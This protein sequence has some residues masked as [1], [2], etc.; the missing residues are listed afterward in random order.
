MNA[1]RQPVSSPAES[2]I[3]VDEDDQEIGFCSKAECHAGE[4]L[5]HRA[6]SV[7]IF[8]SEG[9]LLLQQRSGQKPLW[10]LIWANSCCSHP[11]ELELTEDAARRRV[12]EE[13][14][15]NCELDFLYKFRYQANYR[16][17]GAEHELCH[18]FA[19]YSDEAPVAHPDEIADLRYIEPAELTREIAENGDLYSPWLKMEWQQIQ[20]EFL[21]DILARRASA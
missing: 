3:L 20:A 14:N 10:P 21:D 2:L 15:L 7:F 17:L 13:L 12:R 4:G 9:Q 8:N 16:D 5:L 11:H 18:V 6:F 19:G 1:A